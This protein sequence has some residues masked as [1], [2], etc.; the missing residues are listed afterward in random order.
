MNEH[1]FDY[2]KEY[3]EG[4]TSPQFAVFLKGE[5]GCGKTHFINQ[6]IGNY[7]EESEKI[8]KSEILYI[9]LFG[10]SKT[11]EI[12]DKIFWQSHP[13]LSSKPIKITAKILSL[14][15]KTFTNLGNEDMNA[16]NL[17]I[18]S[19]QSKKLVI[20][21]DIERA[22]L[23]PSQIFGYFYEYL[24]QLGI[25][26]IFIG[27]EK[28]IPKKNDFERIKEKTIGIEF[29]IAPESEIAIASFIDE[30]SLAEE[31]FEYIKNNCFEAIKILN[32]DNLRMVRQ[33]LY[34]LKIL[35][36]SLDEE[37]IEKHGVEISKIFINLFIQKSKCFIT[38][39]TQVHEAIV[40]YEE[41]SVNYQDYSKRKL[42]NKI[43]FLFNQL[44]RY[45]PINNCWEEIIFNG[46]YSKELL[47]TEYEQEKVAS[48]SEQPKKIF[49]LINGWRNMDKETFL[50]I[51]TQT[52]K[53]FT[54][55]IY[56]H[57]GEII[58]YSNIMLIFSIWGLIEKTKD[59][60][61]TLVNDVISKYKTKIL[62]VNDWSMLDMSHAGLSYDISV[63]GLK[64]I[65]DL[66]KSVS[67]ENRFALAKEGIL[68][69]IE[70]M[71]SNIYEFCKNLTHANGVNNYYKIPVLSLVDI[72]IFTNNFIALN[73]SDQVLIISALEERYGKKYTNGESFRQE[74]I[75]D[76]E[77]LV[78][79]TELYDKSLGNV[80]NN[81]QELFKKDVSKRLHDLIKYFEN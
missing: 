13:A 66:I 58:H 36:N 59:D 44:N 34:N 16:G 72:Q 47:L 21:D 65:R 4:E 78:K 42:E 48:V 64:E 75:L 51:L 22:T 35:F 10:V 57:P 56:L 71:A 25:K 18:N 77:N 50:D 14:G 24:Y 31:K 37:I 63:P 68:I 15:L 67:D 81:P 1:V 61:T 11:E 39:K 8:K 41:H 79:F 40:G 38:D 12:D 17:G 73:V 45:I 30:L 70:K 3:I 46:N 76:K 5:W 26:I 74:N 43:P 52:D 6:L 80:L 7:T 2:C 28:H 60:I 33:C 54:N 53:N 55:G 32:C 19:L 23:S 29:L 27:N 9:S 20:V 69:E 49:L 62:V